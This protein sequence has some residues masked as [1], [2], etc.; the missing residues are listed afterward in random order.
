MF[1]VSCTLHFV[2]IYTY[3]GV[4]ILC[5]CSAI[6]YIPKYVYNILYTVTVIACN[7]MSTQNETVGVVAGGGSGLLVARKN[8][9]AVARENN[10]YVY[11]A[12][13]L[14]AHGRRQRSV[15]DLPPP[16]RSAPSSSVCVR[17]YTPTDN[18]TLTVRSASGA[19]GREQISSGMTAAA[20]R[21]R[22]RS[23]SS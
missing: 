3:P 23:P 20:C 2:R 8:L 16:R 15:Y 14:S 12:N 7:C 6:K 5:V 1:K 10:L 18:S 19:N 4:C 13:V 9:T 17:T 21:I 11:Y 22:L